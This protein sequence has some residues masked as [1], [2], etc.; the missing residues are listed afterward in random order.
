MAYILTNKWALLQTIIK[1]LATLFD[2][3]SLQVYKILILWRAEII[4]GKKFTVN[5]PETW[6]LFIIST[7]HLYKEPV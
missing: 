3:C 4:M 2:R 7:Y 1:S 5:L 6:Q